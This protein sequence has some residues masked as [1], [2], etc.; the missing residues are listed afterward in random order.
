MVMQP[1][2][3]TGGGGGGAPVDQ[4]QGGNGGLGSPCPAALPLLRCHSELRVTWRCSL[5]AS[6]GAP[7]LF[8]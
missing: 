2:I 8:C 1:Q 3:S 6:S 7:P 5:C 4:R